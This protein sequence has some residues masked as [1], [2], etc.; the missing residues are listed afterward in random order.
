MQLYDFYTFI[1]IYLYHFQ[2]SGISVSLGMLI[3]AFERFGHS[4][5]AEMKQKVL[6]GWFNTVTSEVKLN[7][8]MLLLLIC[9]TINSFS[10]Y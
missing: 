7:H 4:E 3:E 2:C 10:D 8:K 1:C 6:K 9:I 5:G